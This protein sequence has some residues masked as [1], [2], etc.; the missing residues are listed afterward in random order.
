MIQPGAELRRLMFSMSTLEELGEVLTAR[1]HFRENI[2]TALWSLMGT[3]PVS[4]G[5]LLLHDA[6]R[7]SLTLEAVRGVRLEPGLRVPINPPSAE[8]LRRLRRPARIESPPPGLSRFMRS[9]RFLAQMGAVLLVPL[10]FKEELVGAIAVGEKY[11]GDAY[12]KGDFELIMVMANYIAIGIH[13]Q[14][15]LRNLRSA[16]QKLR[17]KV[18]EN[19][20]LYR[21]L[22]GIYADTVRA[23]GAAIDAKDPYTRGHSDRVAR[24]AVSVAR[25][26]GL[27]E[28]EVNA[29]RIASHLHDVGKIAVDTGILQK[30]GRLSDQEMTQIH[31]HPTVSYDI[32]SNIQFPYPDVALIARHHHERIDGCGYPD[33]IGSEG[34]NA[35]I[36]VITIAD[37]FDAMTSD[38]PYRPALDL[39]EAVRRIL[40]GVGVQFDPAAARAF[41]SVLCDEIT[42]EAVDPAIMPGLTRHFAADEVLVHIESFLRQE[43]F[44]AAAR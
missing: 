6:R 27:P 28:A 37:S 15:L 35:G 19:R 13:N 34:L 14:E 9:S 36:K 3:V 16:N 43:V 22:E 5:A 23:L 40:D 41:L 12:G 25:A 32:L 30:A 18:D 38:R 24:I 8:H 39:A 31:R 10:R 29:L 20:R 21:D 26:L 33:R 7:R 4:R 11:T 2:R 42:G 17:R 44:P 1:S